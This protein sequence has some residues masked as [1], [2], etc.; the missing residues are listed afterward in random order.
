MANYKGIVDE[1]CSLFLVM[2]K[3]VT[4]ALKYLTRERDDLE[5]RASSR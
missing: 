5:S 3:V 1:I 4:S 2:E